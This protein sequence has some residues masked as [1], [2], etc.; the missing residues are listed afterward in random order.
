VH[1]LRSFRSLRELISSRCDSS[2]SRGDRTHVWSTRPRL[3]EWPASFGAYPASSRPAGA[4]SRG[5]RLRASEDAFV[6]ARGRAPRSRRRPRREDDAIRTR[7]GDLPSYAR[8]RALRPTGFAVIVN[9]AGN[10]YRD[11]ATFRFPPARQVRAMTTAMT[12]PL[13]KTRVECLPYWRYHEYLCRVVLSSC[14]QTWPFDSRTFVLARWTAAR[15]DSDD[16]SHWR[17][18]FRFCFDL[19]NP[20]DPYENPFGTI[21]RAWD[22]RGVLTR[23]CRSRVWR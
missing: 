12:R 9:G 20:R 21:S 4:I 2:L 6:F 18:L 11:T 7:G 17:T 3:P 22:V 13:P 19:A 14:C 10:R 5:G 1:S 23:A 15:V 8:D 16:F